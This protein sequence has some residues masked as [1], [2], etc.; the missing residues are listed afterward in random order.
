MICA[1]ASS[2]LFR[3]LLVIASRSGFRETTAL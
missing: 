1:G 3:P 2:R